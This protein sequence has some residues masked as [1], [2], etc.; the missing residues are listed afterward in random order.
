MCEGF[1]A[2][3][4]YPS[5][6]CSW[7]PQMKEAPD[8]LACQILEL[9]CTVLL[10]VRLKVEMPVPKTI[11]EKAVPVLGWL[12]PLPPECGHLTCQPWP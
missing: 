6:A 10:G 3:V 11:S 7:F 1:A 2:A 9:E 8:V 4:S 12:R 5:A